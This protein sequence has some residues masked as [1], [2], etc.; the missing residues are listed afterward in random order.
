[1][2]GFGAHIVRVRKVTSGSLPP[3]ADI[4]QRLEND[5]REANRKA[6][7]DKAYQALLDGYTIRIAKP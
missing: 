6:R 2:S 5:W 3:L 7:E 4:R 1:M